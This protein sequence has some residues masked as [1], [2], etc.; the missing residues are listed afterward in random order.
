MLEY[1]MNQDLICLV[2]QCSTYFHTLGEGWAN[3][4]FLDLHKIE[5]KLTSVK[6]LVF[7]KYLFDYISN[8]KY[9][10]KI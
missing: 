6:T 3:C 1:Q 2:S 5:I 9:I 7:K 10:Y 8:I 4:I